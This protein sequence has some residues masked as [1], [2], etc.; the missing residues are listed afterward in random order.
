M[1]QNRANKVFDKNINRD[2]KRN[3]SLCIKK[4][5]DG[6]LSVECKKFQNAIVKVEIRENAYVYTSSDKV[7]GV[8]GLPYGMN[9]STM[10]M[11]SGGIDSP[12]AGYLMA[13]RGVELKLYIL[14]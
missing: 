7:K 5:Y 3:W 14:S 4:N 6:E 8:G 13:R 1:I 9:G 11:L 12:V 10:L 2:F